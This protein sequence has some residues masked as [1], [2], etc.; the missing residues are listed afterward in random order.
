MTEAETFPFLVTQE[1]PMKRL[2]MLRRAV[3][4]LLAAVVLCPLAQAELPPEAYR[5][6]Q[7][8][9]PEYLTIEVLSVQTQQS[10]EAQGVQIKVEVQ[11]K[12]R[13]AQRSKAGVK[14]GQV[15]T[16]RYGHMVYNQP[17]PGPSQVPILKKETVC[18]A[19]LEK[20]GDQFAPAAGGYSFETVPAE[21]GG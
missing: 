7:A 5:Q 11:A 18:P 10:V 16:I 13:T 15:I 8:K 2:S 6:M 3:L 14:E 12:V 4:V 17:P 1:I 9:A 20:K 19:Y 21:K